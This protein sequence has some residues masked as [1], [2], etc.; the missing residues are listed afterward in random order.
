MICYFW[1]IQQVF[2]KAGI[3]VTSENKRKIDKVFTAL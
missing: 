2:E 3:K 1:H